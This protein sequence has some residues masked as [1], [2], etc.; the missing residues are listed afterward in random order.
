MIDNEK[1]KTRFVELMAK[2]TREGTDKLMAFISKSDFFVSPTS[3]RFH[4]SVEGGLLQHSLNVYDALKASLKDNGD[5]SYSYIVAGREVDRISEESLIIMTLLHDICKTYFYV[6]DYKN[7]KTYDEEK[8]AAAEKWQVKHDNNGDFIWETVETYTVD[9]QVPYGHGEKS[10]MI[11]ESYIKL[12]GCERYAI[13]WHMGFSDVSPTQQYTISA[14]Y[15][16]Y[17]IAWA[18]HNADMQASTFME[19]DRDLTETF[20]D[21]EEKA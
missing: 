18:L 8:V 3:T 7:Q 14:A 21:K 11:L 2:V 9:D 6:K 12:K 15:K 20:Q 10:V 4:L 19:D 1:N 17:P 13:R 5:G 16:K